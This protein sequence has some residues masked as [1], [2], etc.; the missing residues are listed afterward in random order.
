M[1][2]CRFGDAAPPGAGDAA[3]VRGDAA[4]PRWG[5]GRFGEA[6]PVLGGFLERIWRLCG[7]EPAGGRASVGGEAYAFVAGLL[8]LAAGC[9]TA[10]LPGCLGGEAYATAF[11]DGLLGHTAGLR[12]ALPAPAQGIY[13]LRI[14]LA[15]AWAAGCSTA[16]PAGQYGHAAG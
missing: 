4:L 2:E 12:R 16:F 14:P 15:T 13:P 7:H 6:R 9:S 5:K 11:S 10:F 8:N 1:R 3:G